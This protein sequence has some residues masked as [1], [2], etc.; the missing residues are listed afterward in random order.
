MQRWI[1]CQKRS[2]NDK[3]YS[4]SHIYS[5]PKIGKNNNNNNANMCLFAKLKYIFLT[6]FN[7]SQGLGILN[8]TVVKQLQPWAAR[9][10]D[11]NLW[12]PPPIFDDRRAAAGDN[13]SARR[14]YHAGVFN[15]FIAFLCFAWYRY[16]KIVASVRN[17][18][19]HLSPT[20]RVNARFA[21]F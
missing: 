21:G 9:A 7:L 13:L 1:E 11:D 3:P 19:R 17:R 2:K 16:I 12:A 18:S 15:C 5:A 14:R 8:V 20:I 4:K 10:A 6:T